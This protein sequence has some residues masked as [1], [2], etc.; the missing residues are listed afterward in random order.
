MSINN[1][2]WS[3][4]HQN[5]GFRTYGYVPTDAEGFPL[6]ESGV[7]IGYGVDLAY[8][9][10]EWMA[11]VKA[12]DNA[13]GE[14][15]MPYCWFHDARMK[16]NY[17]LEYVGKNPLQINEEQAKMISTLKYTQICAEV[18]RLFEQDSSAKWD[19]LPKYARTIILSVA[20]QYGPNLYLPAD[21]GGCPK[22]WACV[23]ARNWQ[24]VIAELR[25][26][27]DD[28]PT[29]RHREADYLE[30]AVGT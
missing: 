18:C 2:D 15:L 7:T 24:G 5:E 26:F 29:R 6:G 11:K 4:I 17:A 12:L 16:G 28:Y 8:V 25:N 23:C 1:I 9:G 19:E 13:L 30:E 20:I 27:G 22:F 21:K 3:F 14:K 10:A